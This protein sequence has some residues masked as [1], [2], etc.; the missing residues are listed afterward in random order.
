MNTVIASP[1]V[2]FPHFYENPRFSP[3]RAGPAN[4]PS[5]MASRK[6]KAADED[7]GSAYRRERSGSQE[8]S[9]NY[10]RMSA[11]PSSS[12]AILNRQLP[13]P[14]NRTMKRMRTSVTGRP[15]TLPRLLETLD[16]QAMRT[17]LR[18]ICERHPGI[19]AE[20]VATAPRPTVPSALNVL[21]NYE[22]TFRGSFP[23]G[24]NHGSD[25]AYNRVRQALLDL[26]DAL[27]DFTPHFLPPNESQTATSLSFLDGVTEIIH[28]LPVWNNPI[29]NHHK[30]LA[31]EEM[32]KAWALVIR[33]AAKRG[34]GIQLQGGWDQ[35]IVKHNE[36][37]GGR[38]QGAVDELKSGLGWMGHAGNNQ[39]Q[40]PGDLGSI[41]QQLLSGTYG[42]NLPVRVGSW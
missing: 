2:I 1:P 41:R 14:S 21:S 27:G 10:D 36:Q 28:R 4:N 24:G 34:A 25:Y 11:S 32:S 23:F 7:D 40:G 37:S 19:A 15:L 6:R 12:P 13:T 26:L 5:I 20:V 31:Y 39:N 16:A 9:E 30:H 29:N 35:K 38:M 22:S 8:S 3:S 18:S 17:V 33:E 42:S